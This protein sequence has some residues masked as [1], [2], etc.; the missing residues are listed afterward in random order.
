[1]RK[2]TWSFVALA[3]LASAGSARAAVTIVTQHGD[4]PAGTV[5]ID[6]D[7]VRID[8]PEGDDRANVTLVDAAAKK[9]VMINDKE[10]SYIELTDAD[11]Q[12]MKEMIEARRAQMKERLQNVPPD[13]RERIERMMK[14]RGAMGEPAKEPASKFEPTGEKKTINGFSCQMYRRLIDGKVR[15]ELCA[16]PWGAGTLQKSDVAALQKFGAAMEDMGPMR[17]Q[18]RNFLA[19]FDQYPGVPISR[20]PIEPDGKRGEETQIKSI[21]RGAVPASKF[22]IPAG[23]TKK[24]LPMGRGPGMGGPG[25]GGPGRP[26]G[27][28]PEPPVK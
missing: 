19:D 14:E 9:L 23:Y 8:H 25:R 1:M 12:R 22:A 10:K 27:P 17:R 7:H 20:V 4:R 6:G 18:R 13:Q 21:T 26:G 2:L 24:D 5:I 15:E 11:R 28:P 3:G 16:A